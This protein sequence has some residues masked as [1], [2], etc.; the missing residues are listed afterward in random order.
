MA[1]FKCSLALLVLSA[2]LT[3][4]SKKERSEPRA[5]TQQ[6]SPAASEVMAP[7]SRTLTPEERSRHAAGEALSDD[8]II[9]LVDLANSAEVEEGKF[10]ETKAKHTKV[11]NFAA[12]MVMHHGQAK[13]KGEKLATTLSLTPAESSLSSKM[14]N[15]SDSSLAQLKS[16]PSTDFDRAYV[17]AQVDEHKKVL[18]TLDDKLIPSAKDQQLKSL[19][20]EMRTTVHS[21]LVEAQQLQTDLQAK[22]EPR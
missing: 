16:T 13:Q 14:K 7:A 10:A 22:P 9:K 17:D 2:A 21:H 12:K 20:Q 6:P 5:E 3:H 18:S 11:K 1:R 15:E 19:L 8:Q 4:C